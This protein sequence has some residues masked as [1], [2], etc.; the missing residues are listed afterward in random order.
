[1]ESPLDLRKDIE[2]LTEE[3]ESLEE[4]NPTKET[5]LFTKILILKARLFLMNKGTGYSRGF[6]NVSESEID[7]VKG[8]RKCQF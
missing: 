4:L 8:I 3:I 6:T 7:A 2:I 1:M 5:R